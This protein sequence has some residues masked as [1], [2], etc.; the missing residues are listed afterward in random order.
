MPPRAAAVSP[1]CHRH[2]G[3]SSSS[4]SSPCSPVSR[5]QP[6]AR[7]QWRSASCMHL[8]NVCMHACMRLMWRDPF[9]Q[10][11][12]WRRRRRG[13]RGWRTTRRGCRAGRRSR[14]SSATR[15]MRRPTAPAWTCATTAGAAAAAA[16]CHSASP[17]AVA[18]IAGAK[19]AARQLPCSC[20][21]PAVLPGLFPPMCVLEWYDLCNIALGVFTCAVGGFCLLLRFSACT[22]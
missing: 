10:W 11:L 13:R 12:W 14:W 15:G 4:S 22:A 17:G 16:A 5:V 19:P 7:M 18:A 6:Q 20:S 2:R 9:L 8:L 3:A 21:S 1:C